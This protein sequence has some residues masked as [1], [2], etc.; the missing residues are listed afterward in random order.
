MPTS[1]V[2]QEFADELQVSIEKHRFIKLTLGKAASKSQ[3]VKNIYV[4]L[5][6]LKSG[7]VLSFTYRHKKKD[8]VKNHSIP[9][10]IG[11]VKAF[12]GKTF[13]SGN[14]FTT[15]EDIEI[16]Y[17]KKRVPKIFT[18]KPSMQAPN[19]YSHDREKQ[20]YV[21]TKDNTYLLSMGV[22]DQ[23]GEVIKTMQSKFKQINRYI[24]IVDK[25]LQ[26]AE[27]PDKLSIVDMGAGKGYLTFALFDYLKNQLNMQVT[28]KGI[29]EREEL[30]KFC[31]NT[32]R[33]ANF[34]KL[35][36]LATSIADFQIDSVDILI[37][38]HAC[39]TATD[40]A[41]YKGI[42]S[43][44]K[45]IITAPCCHNQIRTQI[46]CTDDI[47]HILKYGI[48]K[49]RQAEIITDG[50]RALLLEAHG[51]K[52]KVFEF[53]STEHTDKNV[54]ITAVKNP[55]MPAPDEILKRVAAIKKQFGIK[56]HYLEKLLDQQKPKPESTSPKN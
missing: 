1:K 28:M 47:C 23:R 35:E 46:D 49:E 34:H 8:V 40:D 56:Q 10:G 13:L 44:A 29:E 45:L 24:E 39:D 11:I 43:G 3:E 19:D 52:T 7:E 20:R 22:I 33:K 25:L 15:K 16:R 30:V 5:I 32:A 31:N 38:L 4:R 12:L 41:I 6:Q 51:Y 27:L 53:I 14:L 48:L 36:F 18:S 37:A 9:E 54:M 55:D 42:C 2:L 50:I 21:E 26:T 17:N